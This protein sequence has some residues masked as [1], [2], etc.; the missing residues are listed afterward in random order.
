MDTIDGKIYKIT[1]LVNGK[2]YVGQTTKTLKVRFRYHCYK[3]SG[4]VAICEAIKKYGKDSFVIEQLDSAKTTEKLNQKEV[5]WINTLN[6]VSPNGY[7]IQIGGDNRVH[8]LSERLNSSIL[9][10]GK[11]FNV[12]KI[13]KSIGYKRKA[14]FKILKTESIGTWVNQ[15]ECAEVLQLNAR[16]INACL[17]G[18]EKYHRGYVF[19]HTDLESE[20]KR[21]KEISERKYFKKTFKVYKITEG[22]GKYGH[23][24]FRVL[25]TEFVGTWN[26]SSDCASDLEID[27]KYIMTC[28]EK[29][30]KSYKKYIFEYIDN[31]ETNDKTS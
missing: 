9:R 28:L 3:Y 5:S 7:N 19:E 24:Y 1:N 20:E 4:C 26:L 13:I 27:R 16:N 8:S 22:S 30:Q 2:V 10:G 15:N 14:N 6:S 17:K 29:R 31:G 21:Q 25:K 23:R 18:K 12:Y 11:E